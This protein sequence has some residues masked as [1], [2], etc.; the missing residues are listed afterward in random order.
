MSDSLLMLIDG[1][2]IIYR[3]YHAFPDLT[4]PQ[5][6]L[7]NAVYGFT[8]I[9]LTAIRDFKPDYLAVAFDHPTPTFRHLKFKDYKAN[10]P[11]M[12][13]DLKPQIEVIKQIVD[14]LNIPKFELEG[15]EADD[16][17][18]TLVN[19]AERMTSNDLDLQSLVVTGDKDL[20]QLV[21]DKTH[22]FLPGRGKQSKDQEYD[23]QAVNQRFGLTP[24]QIIDLKALMGDASDNIPGV[25]GVGEKTAEK[26]ILAFG[27]LEALYQNVDKIRQGEP[28]LISQGEALLKGALLEKLISGREDAFMS[29]ELATIDQQVPIT[30]NLED[31]RVS[32]YDKQSAVELLEKLGFK[33]LINILPADDFELGIQGALF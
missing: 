29:H 17:I 11:E 30:L 7:V 19:Q 6:M 14:I 20:L 15:F 32:G 12:P 24:H 16:V 23:I 8:R 10:R 5:G 13:D 4:T 27:T 22:V 9:V 28:S 1:H 25:R 3:A 26:L 21:T 18:G 2:A 31:C 33:S